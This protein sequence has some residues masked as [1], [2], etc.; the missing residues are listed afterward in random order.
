MFRK[1]LAHWFL[2]HSRW[3][4]TSVCSSGKVSFL[5]NYGLVWSDYEYHPSVT[6]AS[7]SIGPVQE[8]VDVS[9]RLV[10]IKR[11]YHPLIDSFSPSDC[12]SSSFMISVHALAWNCFPSAPVVNATDSLP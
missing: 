7:H 9:P 2:F 1:C 10:K 3:S 12:S 6:L 11:F 4:L 8:G 5:S